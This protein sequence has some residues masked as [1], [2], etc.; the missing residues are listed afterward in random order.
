MR[1]SIR[2]Q[3]LRAS[4]PYVPI[5]AAQTC[6]SPPSSNLPRTLCWA[7]DLVGKTDGS[8]RVQG[9]GAPARSRGPAG[10]V[11]RRG[12]QPDTDVRS[13][14]ERH[15]P[16][17]P[18][19]EAWYWAMDDRGGTGRRSRWS[20]GF[21]QPSSRRAPRRCDLDVGAWCT[22]TKVLASIPIP[23][24]SLQIRPVV[25]WMSVELSCRRHSAVP[26]STM[27]SVAANASG[28]RL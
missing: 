17:L 15:E 4:W 7:E 2:F 9:A 11:N 14:R 19:P 13:R 8:P 22:S 10:V 20:P 28:T 27:E 21:P 3:W 16:T 25:A 12:T 18:P 6:I 24:R 26:G 1:C 5:R 23:S